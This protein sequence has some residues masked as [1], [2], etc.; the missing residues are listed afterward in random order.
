MTDLDSPPLDSSGSKSL[1]TLKKRKKR[2]SLRAKA[3]DD[4]GEQSDEE[5]HTSVADKM[6]EL[7]SDQATRTKRQKVISTLDV[8]GLHG[9][10][11]GPVAEKSM[12]EMMGSQFAAQESQ[13]YGGTISHEN[14]LESYIK[15]KT[16]RTESAVAEVELSE[17]EL[18][19]RVPQEIKD[20]EGRPQAEEVVGDVAEDTKGQ[21][22]SISTG[23]SEVALPETYKMSNIVATEE[24]RR[25]KQED[26]K[27]MWELKKI[28]EKQ[29]T[30]CLGNTAVSYMRKQQQEEW[31]AQNA[32]A[33]EA[34]KKEAMLKEKATKKYGQGKASQANG[35]QQQEDGH[36]QPYP[37]FEK[38]TD[39]AV[40]EGSARIKAEDCTDEMNAEVNMLM[41]A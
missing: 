31:K 35:S 22:L 24:A 2:G 26:R 17:E 9:R 8:A 29:K 7:K 41:S 5:T 39:N 27:S 40:M 19:Y 1:V 6:A 18:L 21:V 36:R 12:K 38:S 25:K 33:T 34:A 20:M 30:L 28:Q 3:K 32:A 23:I 14:L 15:E 11:E 10:D 37:S 16:G 4:N 13:Q